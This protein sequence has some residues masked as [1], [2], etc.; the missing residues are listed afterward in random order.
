MF[1]TEVVS[2]F[3]ITI[4]TDDMNDDATA[5]MTLREVYVPA[6]PTIPADTFTTQLKRVVSDLSAYTFGNTPWYNVGGESIENSTAYKLAPG[7]Q[8]MWTGEWT[9][10][11][12][13]QSIAANRT[14]SLVY[15]PPAA[16]VV[17]LEG[18]GTGSVYNTG[19]TPPSPVTTTWGG[20]LETNVQV[21]TY[22]VTGEPT[23]DGEVYTWPVSYEYTLTTTTYPVI[24]TYTHTTSV[25]SSGP[26]SAHNYSAADAYTGLEHDPAV[27]Y[28]A[29][30]ADTDY[31]MIAEDFS[32]RR[33]MGMMTKNE[34]QINIG[35]GTGSVI[36][37]NV[38]LIIKN[39]DP[40]K[41]DV[42]VYEDM[43]DEFSA[44]LQYEAGGST[45]TGEINP[46]YIS[47]FD[48][49]AALPDRTDVPQEN[50]GYL[51]N[52]NLSA[53]RLSL[54]EWN[55]SWKY[56][57]SYDLNYCANVSS[58]NGQPRDYSASLP[59]P[60]P[61]DVMLASSYSVAS[62]SST[63]GV[64]V[65]DIN[66][67]GVTGTITLNDAP[68]FSAAT[69]N[70]AYRVEY[71]WPYTP[72]IVNDFP[73]MYADPRNETFITQI[74]G[75]GLILGTGMSVIYTE[76]ML[77][78]LVGNRFGT[79]PLEPQITAWIEDVNKARAAMTPPRPAFPT[80]AVGDLFIDYDEA[81]PFDESPLF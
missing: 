18:S 80:Y 31:R 39:R 79:I 47:Y 51:N 15:A 19:E 78:L 48:P 24:S 11:P 3:E 12:G 64:S 44:V 54:T 9:V 52:G 57:L 68:T 4:P 1:E 65:A 58:Y 74:A 60:T 69:Y 26:S 77:R 25:T 66:L 2:E 62:Y 67:F 32:P 28:S 46:P 53:P 16:N 42:V 27:Y 45:A 59:G 49:G 63:F 71:L 50:N 35:G 72:Q 22:T 75:Y 70:P 41:P 40:L 36:T 81:L 23:I 10:M 29:S 55:G 6:T 13:V 43:L 21:T 14:K 30:F 38:S 33:L 5:T 61:F 73:K 34:K 8:D 76:P 7:T 56:H 37:S 20:D 17:V